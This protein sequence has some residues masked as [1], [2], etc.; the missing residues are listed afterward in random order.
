AYFH[1]CPFPALNLGL[2]QGGAAVNI[3]ADRCTLDVGIRLLPGQQSE[4]A[5]QEL[6]ACVAMLPEH[7]A[8]NTTL[9]IIN[10]SPPMLCPA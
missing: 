1:E 2:I 6:N 9:T 8:D 5:M 10:D 7:G 3:V 4:S